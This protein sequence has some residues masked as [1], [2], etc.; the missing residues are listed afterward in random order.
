MTDT[1]NLIRRGAGP[2]HALAR[3]G[4]W[5]TLCGRNLWRYIQARPFEGD[6]AGVTC[7]DCARHLEHGTRQARR[8]RR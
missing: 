7:A 1:R 5:L 8:Y 3:D 6:P 2:V 4:L